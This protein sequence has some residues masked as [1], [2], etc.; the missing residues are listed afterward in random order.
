MRNFLQHYGSPLHVYCRLRSIMRKEWALAVAAVY[1]F[2]FYR[3]I[4]P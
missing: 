4:F 3:I 2:K 1:D